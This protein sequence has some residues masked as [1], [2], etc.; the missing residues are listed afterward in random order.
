MV[1]LSRGYREWGREWERPSPG[2][3]RRCT[4]AGGALEKERLETSEIQD[5]GM[6]WTWNCQ[7]G[8]GMSRYAV[9]SH[10]SFKTISGY[11]QKPYNSPK[12]RKIL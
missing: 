11:F 1:G 4:L 2:C 5:L 6:L 10:F 9:K 8:S 7:D 12:P 3:H